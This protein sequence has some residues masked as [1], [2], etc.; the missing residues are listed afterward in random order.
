MSGSVEVV[1]GDTEEY[2]PQ[3]GTWTDARSGV[4]AGVRVFSAS[5]PSESPRRSARQVVSVVYFI[6]HFV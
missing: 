4:R 1:K 5:I 2:M 3:N 6:R